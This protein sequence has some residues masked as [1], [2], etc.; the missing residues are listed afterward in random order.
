[1]A[2][3][4]A[5]RRGNIRKARTK[6]KLK[7]AAKEAAKAAGLVTIDIPSVTEVTSTRF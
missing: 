3:Q 2:G 4:G 5:K 1:M 6:Q 7:R